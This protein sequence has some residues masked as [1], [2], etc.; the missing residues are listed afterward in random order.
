[1]LEEKTQ[2]SYGSGCMTSV[3]CCS[4]GLAQFDPVF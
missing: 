4:L 2:T 1:M 3:K